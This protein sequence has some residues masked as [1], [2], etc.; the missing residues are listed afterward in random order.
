MQLSNE[1]EREL[2]FF[3]E[4][5][6][7]EYLTRKHLHEAL[8]FVKGFDPP[9]RVRLVNSHDGNLITVHMGEYVP[10][11]GQILTL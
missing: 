8:M 3:T 6:K 4:T 9:Y 10:D 1:P 5:E 11:I 7:I 2:E